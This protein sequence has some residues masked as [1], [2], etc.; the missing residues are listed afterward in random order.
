MGAEVGSLPGLG[1]FS[2]R[3]GSALGAT[4]NFAVHDAFMTLPPYARTGEGQAPQLG[5]D[6]KPC[7]VGL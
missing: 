5:S 1:A 2:H 4:A 3:R 6:P 7:R